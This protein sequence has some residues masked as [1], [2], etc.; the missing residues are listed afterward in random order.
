VEGVVILS[1]KTDATGHVQ[2]VMI[3]RSIPLL[4]Q[5]ALDAVRQWV[6]EPLVINGVAKPVVFTVTVRFQLP[7]KDKTKKDL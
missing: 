2:D 6:Y 4:N 3:L 5:A 7:E 1:A